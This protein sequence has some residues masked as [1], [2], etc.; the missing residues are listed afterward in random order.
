MKIEYF[1]WATFLAAALVPS[2]C[3]GKL[4]EGS[5]VVLTKP[6][7]VKA[8]ESPI[9]V[10]VI[11]DQSASMKNSGTAVIQ[12]EEL[13]PLI[14]QLSECGGELG[15]T[16]VRESPEPG[17][18]RIRFPEKP[19]LP[20]EPLQREGEEA[21][22][23]EDRVS[24]Y[25]EQLVKRGEKIDHER[26]A[27][28]PKIESFLTQIRESLARR[29]SNA[30][31]LNSALNAAD[32]FLAEEGD[33]ARSFL[34]IVSDGIDTEKRAR[35][36]KKSGVNVL[37]VNTTTEEKKSPWPTARRFENFESAVRFVSTQ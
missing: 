29:H 8:C 13:I 33:A 35:L 15:V 2:S 11:G 7:V 3:A 37:W 31:D 27:L 4:A 9:D 5:E 19:A 34:I 17:I 26:T 1:I 22:E 6:P 36:D 24:A 28:K 21:Y 10:V 23:F 20:E 14:Q 32:I 12:A 25:K 16:F 18:K 30:T